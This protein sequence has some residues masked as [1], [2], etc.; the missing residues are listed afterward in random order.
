MVFI[1]KE[2]HTKLILDIYDLAE[3]VERVLLEYITPYEEGLYLPNQINPILKKGKTYYVIK[4]GPDG[5]LYKE[6]ISDL[7]AVRD[8][9]FDEFGNEVIAAKGN[10]D[11]NRLLRESPTLP[12]KG[13]EFIKDYTYMVVFNLVQW[14]SF[15][16]LSLRDLLL[17]TI[18]ENEVVKAINLYGSLYPR[19][20]PQIDIEEL[21]D[22]LR[23]V[24]IDIDTEIKS[25]MNNDYMNMYDIERKHVYLYITKMQ[26]RRIYEYEQ[27]R[28]EG[29]L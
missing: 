6:P 24:L 10:L 4:C 13:M 3:Q 26:D 14:G 22:R 28:K 9:V 21:S 27:L 12:F 15:P 29:V 17:K 20:S 5:A 2:V 23:N 18:S 1:P 25:F 16:R 7:G 19:Q 8:S 11:I